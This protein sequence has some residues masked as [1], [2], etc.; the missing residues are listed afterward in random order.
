LAPGEK[1]LVSREEAAA[2]LSISIRGVDYYIAAKQLS[3]R[4]KGTRVLIPIEDVRRLA[5]ADHPERMA[6]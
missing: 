2:L 5:R 3:T 6:G 1:L 4:R